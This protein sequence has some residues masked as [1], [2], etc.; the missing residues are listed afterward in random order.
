VIGE[1][2]AV[3]RRRVARFV[4]WIEATHPEIERPETLAPDELIALADEFEGGRVRGNRGLRESWRVG[5]VDHLYEGRSD[6]E[7]DD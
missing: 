3:S 2:V 6:F 4:A 7:P 1:R 5:F